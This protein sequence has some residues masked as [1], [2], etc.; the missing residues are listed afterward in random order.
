[1]LVEAF[2]AT[3]EE[4]TRSDLI[5]A[6]H[7]GSEDEVFNHLLATENVLKELKTEEI[8]RFNV[9]NKTDMMQE[10]KKNIIKNKLP[11]AIFISAKEKT[12][13]DA[14]SNKMIAFFESK[15][16]SL[17]LDIPYKDFGSYNLL[18]QYGSIQ[19]EH[20]ND[21]GILVEANVFY[22][23]SS[24]FAKFESSYK[25]DIEQSKE[26]KRKRRHRAVTAEKRV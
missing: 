8:P 2:N 19:E 6:V 5:L 18:Q 1:M 3:L 22:R 24:I 25:E 15:M 13:F 21:T 14:L 16:V 11:D 9:I 17:K 20:K 4:I 12:N 23:Y 7:D 10:D 26:C